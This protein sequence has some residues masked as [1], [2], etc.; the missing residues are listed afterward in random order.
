MFCY[1]SYSIRRR[2][3]AN[4][5]T[6]GI[7]LMLV[8]LLNLYFGSLYSYRNQLRDLSQNVPIY[9]RVLNRNGTLDSSLFIPERTLNGLRA[10]DQIKDLTYI[11][12]LMAGEGDFKLA[13]LQNRLSIQVLGANCMV[14]LGEQAS[15]LIDME[16]EAAEE[17]L[18]SDRRECIVDKT[19]MRR[20]KWEVGDTVILKCYYVGADSEFNKREMHPMGGTVEVKIVGT[21]AG[22]EG[23]ILLPYDAVIGIYQQFGHHCFADW[24]A[25]YVKDPLQLNEFKEEMKDIGLAEVIP[26]ASDS[27]YGCALEVRDEHFVTGGTNLKRS[28]EMLQLFFPVVCVMVLMIGYVVS[29]L[30]GNSR[31]EEYAL[32]RLQGV[33]KIKSSLLFLSEQMILV[34]AGNLIG[35]VL[36]VFVAPSV[37]LMFAVNGLLLLAYVI[38]SA[39]AYG[40]MSRGSVVALLSAQR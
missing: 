26:T 10:T 37:P 2:K 36:M 19:M 9:C 17:L 14:A 8:I 30:S 13:E 32:L 25:F 40:R 20:R 12:R 22:V 23:H 15:E 6:V 24:T 27:Y 35:D 3:A 21:M 16:T 4:L 18:Q 1:V 5:V 7:S 39:A 31:R 28:I 11:T 38:G 34:L 33:K 29:Y